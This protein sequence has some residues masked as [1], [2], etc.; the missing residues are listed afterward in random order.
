VTTVHTGEPWAGP[1]PI[2]LMGLSMLAGLA[3]VARRRLVSLTS[4]LHL[5]ARRV[6]PT[7]GQPP[8]PA[9]GTS[10]VPPPVSGP[11]RRLPN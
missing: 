2:A 1:L 3:V 9:S 7:G 11:A 8:G 4:R 5:L 10:S 6:T